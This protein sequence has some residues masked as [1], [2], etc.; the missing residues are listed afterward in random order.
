MYLTHLISGNHSSELL[1]GNMDGHLLSMALHFK[2]SASEGLNCSSYL[3]TLGYTI[4]DQFGDTF[5]P[6]EFVANESFN[7]DPPKGTGCVA[8][9]FKKGS[10]SGHGTGFTDDFF[11]CSDACP[12]C[13]PSG[14][15]CTLTSTQTWKVNGFVVRKNSV[16][17]TCSDVTI[18]QIP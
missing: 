12:K 16:T 5:G 9:G 11:L 1:S 8:T 13:N 15:G 3:R 17:W 6:F 2:D 18:Q 4:K 10:I 7:P 14:Q